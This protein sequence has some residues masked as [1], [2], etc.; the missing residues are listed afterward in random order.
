MPTD[1]AIALM[2]KAQ[3]EAHASYDAPMDLTIVCLWAALG[4]ALTA[5][6]LIGF[7]PAFAE[8]LVG[9]G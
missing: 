7:D 3:A 8:V 5:L 6:M 2:R 4:L 9:V 1:I